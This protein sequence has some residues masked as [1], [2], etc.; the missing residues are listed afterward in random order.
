[1]SEFPVILGG[2]T[3]QGMEVP[4]RIAFGGD[5]MLKVHK[6]VGGRRVIDA[7]GADDM[8]L[9]WTGRF[10]GADALSR[11]MALDQMR[12]DGQVQRLQ[13]S[14]L[15]YDVVIKTFRADFEK[16]YNL[17]YAICCEV[18]GSNGVDSS[19]EDGAPI[20]VDQMVGS[21]LSSLLGSASA[22]GNP[23]FSGNVGAIQTAFNAIP[24][25]LGASRSDINGIF[26]PVAAA[27]ATVGGLI[28]SADTILAAAPF[29]GFVAGSSP[30]QMALSLSSMASAGTSAAGLRDVSHTLGRLGV[31]LAD[32][33]SAGAQVVQG[34]G[35]L[36]R[37]SA[38]AYGDVTHWADI[39]KAN[40]LT[41]PV[42]TGV[43]TLT[44]PAVPP[45]SGGVLTP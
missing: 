32:V 41:D 24:S 29:A 21:D 36:Y 7:M 27:Q 13:W 6:L 37:L 10:F 40:G 26:A 5:Q 3:F 4:D 1:M 44:I 30:A 18:V 12:R 45:D 15:A 28:A 2:V 22:L 31:N 43:N 16:A 34:G 33:S 35:D 23:V 14:E 20:S 19:A 38:R 8:A 17:P 25:L 9:E 39:A 11:A 42:L